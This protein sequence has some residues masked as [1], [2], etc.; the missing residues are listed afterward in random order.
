M[1]SCNAGRNTAPVWP[2]AA[3]LKAR[4]VTAW[5]E[6]R[7]AK[8]QVN[9]PNESARPVRAGRWARGGT[10]QNGSGL[11]GL[12]G[13][14]GARYLGLRSRC[15]L[16]PRLSHDGPTALSM[17]PVPAAEHVEVRFG[18]RTA[19]PLNRSIRRE[20]D[21]IS[22]PIRMIRLTPDATKLMRAGCGFT[23]SPHRG[24]GPG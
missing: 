6:A 5:G 9:I 8:P 12:R 13:F 21:L 2:W 17:L 20:P 18:F 10:P 23:H 14:Y 11:S 24:R 22:W 3:G 1:V 16:Q 15:S 19:R 4:D 7:S